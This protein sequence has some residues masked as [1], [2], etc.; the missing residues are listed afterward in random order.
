M[1]Q[2]KRLRVFAFLWLQVN[3]V[4]GQMR[5]CVE[6]SSAVHDLREPVITFRFF[7]GLWVDIYCLVALHV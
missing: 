3:P 2:S 4:G 7:A 5:I 6:K 1:G